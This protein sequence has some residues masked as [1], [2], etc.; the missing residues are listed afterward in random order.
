MNPT[1]NPEPQTA[2]VES[3]NEH[4]FDDKFW[5]SLDFVT[6]AVDNVKARKYVDCRCVWYEKPLLESGTLG[7]K[8]NV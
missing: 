5:E 6:N 3:E 4:I 7:P 1:F 8:A 2:R